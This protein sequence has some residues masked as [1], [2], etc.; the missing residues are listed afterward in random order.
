MYTLSGDTIH[1]NGLGFTQMYC[2]PAALEEQENAYFQTLQR[3]E[4]YHLEGYT[5]TLTSTDGSVELIFRVN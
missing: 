2:L 1:V 3:V 4:R 5:L